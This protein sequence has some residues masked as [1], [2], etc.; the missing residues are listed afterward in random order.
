MKRTQHEYERG[1]V[2]EDDPPPR[3]PAK[4]EPQGDEPQGPWE[5]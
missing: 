5:D 3:P 1:Y 4:E 2:D